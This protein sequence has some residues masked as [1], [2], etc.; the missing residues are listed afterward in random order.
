MIRRNCSKK[1]VSL[2]LDDDE[3]EQC[4]DKLSLMNFLDENEPGLARV[5]GMM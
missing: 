5:L 4:S 1:D 3:E 2:F